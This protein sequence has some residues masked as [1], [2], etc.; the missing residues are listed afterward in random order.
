MWN[1]ACDVQRRADREVTSFGDAVTLTPIG[2]ETSGG[3]PDS[4]S[5]DMSEAHQKTA[6]A[7]RLVLF[8]PLAVFGALAGVLSWGL[9]RDPS[10]LPSQLIGKSAP[11]FTLPPLPGRGDGFATEDLR[12]GVSLVNVFASWCPPCREE[13]PLLM[14]LKERKL[15]T[16]FGLNYKD[17]PQDA[18]GWLDELGDPYTRIGSDIDGRVAIEWGVY[19]VPETFVVDAKGVVLYKH[20]GPL[21]EDALQKA[22]L[23]LVAASQRQS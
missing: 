20:V 11:S 7:R 19:G 13:H 9:G 16:I 22:I 10:N 17:Q 6:F 3:A 14:Q 1:A 12:G 18:V 5:T 8:A 2:N 15:V 21:T 23:P 4:T